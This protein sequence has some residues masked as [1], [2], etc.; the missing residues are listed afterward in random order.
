M[1]LPTALAVRNE[2]WL[3]V[4]AALAGLAALAV[5]LVPRLPNPPAH[6]PLWDVNV[7]WWG[8][9]QALHGAAIYA[10]AAPYH[11][12]YP[13]FAAAL[14]GIGAIAPEAYLKVAISA[15]SVCALATLS[16]MTLGA[17]GVRRRPEFVFAAVALALLTV[18]VVDTLRLG[19]TD[20]IV[21]ALVGADLLRRQDGGRWQGIGT[22]LAA[23]IKLTPL[24]F[25]AY[26]LLT[27]RI[28]AA[29]VAAGTFAAT[30]TAGFMLLPSDS[31]TFWLNGVFLHSR[32]VGNPISPDNQSLAGAVARLAGGLGTAMPWW[33]AAAVLTGLAGLA[34]AAWAHRRSHRLAGAV[35]CG[36]TALLVSPISWTHHWIWVVPLLVA[37]GVAAWRRR[38]LWYAVAAAAIGY[39]FSATISLPSP[40][41]DPDLGRLLAGDAY[42]LCGLVVLAAAALAVTLKRSRTVSYP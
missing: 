20:L 18:P 19:E 33:L 35:Y 34:V 15:A 27:R 30:V 31:R 21:T 6:W 26:L 17:A 16:W 8:G 41:R 38:S 5:Y 32:R 22:G 40:G 1:R 39:V 28:R 4:A 23:G 12:T 42:V 9:A 7:Y 37:L 14:F 2:S 36:I 10:R 24:I 13:P 29:A 25:V 3:R 11:F